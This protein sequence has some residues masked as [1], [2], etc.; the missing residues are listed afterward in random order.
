MLAAGQRAAEAEDIPT[1]GHLSPSQT[2][3]LK[4][5]Q[6]HMGHSESERDSVH[7]MCLSQPRSP[8]GNLAIGW[9]FY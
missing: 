4:G 1:G 2:A 8:D 3:F 6:T 7:Q 5:E 9:S